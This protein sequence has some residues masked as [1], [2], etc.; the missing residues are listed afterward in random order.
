MPPSHY[1][2]KLEVLARAIKERVY[3]LEK[4]KTKL[5]S[6]TD[7]TIIYAENPKEVTKKQLLGTNKRL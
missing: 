2:L 7:H 1:C 6:F 4:T 5:P 3:R